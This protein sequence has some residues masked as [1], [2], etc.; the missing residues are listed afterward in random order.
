VRPR[1]LE[2]DLLLRRLLDALADG[3]T[4]DPDTV[5]RLL[6]LPAT[7]GRRK[8]LAVGLRAAGLAAD[9]DVPAAPREP[10]HV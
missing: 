3:T 7:A 8:R 6:E 1:Q 10:A 9:D 2:P 4:L 5:E